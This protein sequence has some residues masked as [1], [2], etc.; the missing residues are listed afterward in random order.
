M[1][2][3]G[4]GRRRLVV[5][6]ELEQAADWSPDGKEILFTRFDRSG[7]AV[8]VM[9]AEGTN[10]RKLTRSSGF[11][12]AAAWSPDGTKILYTSGLAAGASQLFLMD[13]DGS[14]IRDI[15]GGRFTG[16]EPSWR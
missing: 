7:A 1:N 5:S 11:D 2:S 3:D 12:I 4:T 15:T 14:N 13:A 8:M 6:E 10:I 9:S 16:S